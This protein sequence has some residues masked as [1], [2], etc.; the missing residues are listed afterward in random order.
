MLKRFFLLALGSFLCLG[1]VLAM[2]ISPEVSLRIAQEFFRGSSL[3]SSEPS[4]TL[5]YTHRPQKPQAKQTHLRASEVIA[6]T[7]Y[8]IYNKGKMK[9]L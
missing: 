2:P 5:S 7:Y 6:P 9:A 4:L 3:R 8:Y 1:S